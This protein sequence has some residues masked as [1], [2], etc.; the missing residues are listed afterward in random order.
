[1]RTTNIYF[2]VYFLGGQTSL[3][4]K[5]LILW[6]KYKHTFI[7]LGLVYISC[8][9]NCSYSPTHL[10][11]LQGLFFQRCSIY[12]KKLA[13]PVFLSSRRYLH[14]NCRTQAEQQQKSSP[15]LK[16]YAV[17]MQYVLFVTWYTTLGIEALGIVTKQ[18]CRL[19]LGKI[20]RLTEPAKKGQVGSFYRY[21]L[22]P[23]H[24]GQNGL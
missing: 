16:Y 15:F 11:N 20:Y 21:R 1:M 2:K 18:I 23:H 8:Q 7:V 24:T 5:I 10:H 22:I 9:V 4:D 3:K 6:L 12:F 13:R 19:Q 17:C 14:K